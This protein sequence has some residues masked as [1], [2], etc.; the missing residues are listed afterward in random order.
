[1]GFFFLLNDKRKRGAGCVPLF[2]V[3]FLTPQYWTIFVEK[4]NMADFMK[5]KI[6][7]D[8]GIRHVWQM[9]QER[10][11]AEFMVHF[12]RSVD[13]GKGKPAGE[14]VA[15]TVRYGAPPHEKKATSKGQGAT[16]NGQITNR[17]VS[18]HDE[19][20]TI[21]VYYPDTLE[22]RS[23]LISHIL[24]FDGWRVSL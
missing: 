21:P 8:I 22:Y 14:I 4:G 2:F 13:G 18:Q 1:M 17:K 3:S 9:L 10:P 11:S 23:L 6:K 20:G 19:A 12:V 5:L 15:R 7:G 24:V 16:G